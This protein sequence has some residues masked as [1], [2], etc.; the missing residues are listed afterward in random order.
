MINLELTFSP[1]LDEGPRSACILV[2]HTGSVVKVNSTTN[3]SLALFL[4]TSRISDEPGL[5][6]MCHSSKNL[7]KKILKMLNDKP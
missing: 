1:V 7:I 4:D 5:T 3:N 6:G 2:V